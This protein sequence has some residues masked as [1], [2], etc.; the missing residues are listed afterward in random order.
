MK[1]FVQKFLNAVIPSKKN[2]YKPLL[3]SNQ[4]LA[5]YAVLTMLAS[6][7]FYYTE[8][9][10][11]PGMFARI[12][13]SIV[14]DQTNIQ[15]QA[16]SQVSLKVNDKLVQAATMK[17]QDMIDRDY[18]SHNGPDG[19]RP[20]VWLQRA[21]YDY[22]LAGENLA[23]DFF[24][25]QTVVNAWM[26]SPS[27]ARNI[28]NDYFTDIGIGVAEGEFNGR[29]T[30]VVVMF[31]GREVS[32]TL[33]AVA[34]TEP[35]PAP[36]PPTPPAPAPAPA[37]TPTPSPTPPAPA[38]EPA[39]ES[40][41]A[42]GDTVE[43]PSPEKIALVSRVNKSDVE[44]ESERIKEKEVNGS[45][46][47]NAAEST[48][49]SEFVSFEKSSVLVRNGLRVFMVGLIMVS[50]ITGVKHPEGVKFAIPRVFLLGF[51]LSALSV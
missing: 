4:A 38:P 39:P 7:L 42:S 13:Q 22:A 40:V 34:I 43:N 17:A 11:T 20:W 15:R 48:N 30:T 32:P 14:V 9:L 3:L 45:A 18:F 46:F 6:T 1:K 24:D 2:G 19:E 41:F 50:A 26:N 10:H 36:A 12:S 33:Q 47:V 35:E 27:H 21:N 25:P 8:G 29:Q 28:L 23:I 31:L 16:Q 37:P 49:V 5:S 44:K 51:L